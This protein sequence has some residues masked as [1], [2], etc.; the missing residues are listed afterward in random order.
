MSKINS[1]NLVKIEDI[2]EFLKTK[3]YIWNGKGCIFNIHH[4][5]EYYELTFKD[6]D[7]GYSNPV[8]VLLSTD[9]QRYYDACLNV[10]LYYVDIL[11]DFYGFTNDTR[12]GSETTIAKSYDTEFIEFM[13]KKYGVV[14][15]YA[16]YVTTLFNK[17]IDS[18]T[19]TLERL[20]TEKETLEQKLLD[21]HHFI[22]M[23]TKDLSNNKRLLNTIT[24][25]SKNL[26]QK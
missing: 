12:G 3:G 4:E 13:V 17:N 18:Y 22:D 26:Y 1:D 10:G 11:E 9:G 19:S 8:R 5:P 6:F 14:S 25:L 20:K 16:K 2:V 15:D 21:N 24:N 7:L 23:Y